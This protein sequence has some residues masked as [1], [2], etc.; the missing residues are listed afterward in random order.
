VEQLSKAALKVKS[1]KHFGVAQSR[2]DFLWG[3]H[4]VRPENPTDSL[5]RPFHKTIKSSRKYATPHFCSWL[6]T[7]FHV[8]GLF[9]SLH[10]L[11]QYTSTYATLN[12]E[13]YLFKD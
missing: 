2:D 11:L 9:S 4:L 12:K 6:L 5:C 1:Q 13:L 7:S 3:G 8:I 10:K